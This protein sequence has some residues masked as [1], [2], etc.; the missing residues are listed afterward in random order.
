MTSPSKRRTRPPANLCSSTSRAPRTCLLTRSSCS[1]WARTRSTVICL[2][3]RPRHQQRPP[4]IRRHNNQ[5]RLAL[6]VQVHFLE[7]DTKREDPE[8]PPF[9][10]ARFNLL[11]FPASN[12]QLP[13]DS[14]PALCQSKG[15]RMDVI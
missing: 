2:H 10:F 15:L 11:A 3:P 6:S 1:T 5:L 8:N 13:L 14:F 7:S 9:S 4:A 12:N